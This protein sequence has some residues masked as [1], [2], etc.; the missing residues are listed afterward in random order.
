MNRRDACAQTRAAR[1]GMLGNV[2][3]DRSPTALPAIKRRAELGFVEG[4]NAVIEYR[5]SGG[6]VERLPELSRELLGLKPDLIM[7]MGPVLPVRALR[8]EQASIPVVFCAVDYDPVDSG[9]VASY[10]RLGGNFTGAYIPQPA[11]AVKRFELAREILPRAK[12]LLVFYDAFCKDQF[13]AVAQAATRSGIGIE[14]IEFTRPPYDYAAAFKQGRQARAQALVGLMSPLFFQDRA[15]IAALALKD[16]LPA[17][18]GIN[19]F[20]EAGFL[21]SYGAPLAKVAE[22]A[23]EIAARILKGAKPADTPVEQVNEFEFAV[24][25]K[26]TKALGI[27][28]PQSIIVRAHRVIE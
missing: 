25:L 23:A 1:I 16:R 4:K 12:R 28:I 24:N 7:V 8:D 2:D 20:A 21:A 22:R 17:V 26:T 13:T 11:L 5:F 14:A 10:N 6:V 27:T 3:R 18:G 19:A 15:Q 9:I